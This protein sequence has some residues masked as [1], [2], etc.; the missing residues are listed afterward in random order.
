MADRSPYSREPYALRAGSVTLAIAYRPA[1]AWVPPL[2][3]GQVLEVLTG[4]CEPKGLGLLTQELACQRV[5]LDDVKNAALKLVC[6]AS[7]WR[8]WW[9]AVRL[10]TL[11]ESRDGI[12][13]LALAGL[14]PWNMSLAQWCCATYVV[15][16]QH[17]KPEDQF[18][19]DAQLATPPPGIVDTWDDGSDFDMMVQASRSLPG[20]G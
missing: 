17:L 10:C 6:E 14:N 20:M 19:F 12:G 2:A 4:F 8:R 9:E 13:H 7:G 16:T 18:K 1:G 11:S 15:Y 5:S 3:S